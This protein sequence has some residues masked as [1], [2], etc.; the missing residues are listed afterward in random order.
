MYIA[1]EQTLRYR[2]E[3]TCFN[4]ALPLGNGRIGAM[5]YGGV[6]EET[7]SLNEDTL[8]S[9]YPK[10]GNL[11]D[12]PTIHRK[13]MELYE[14][15]SVEEAQK[16]LEGNFGD[17]LVQ[18]YLP[19]ADLKIRTECRDIK[20]YSRYLKLDSA[21]HTVNYQAN[22]KSYT[23]ETLVSEPY[24]VMAVRFQCKEKGSIN[25]EA[26]IEGRLV[27]EKGKL[28]KGNALILYGTAPNCEA[29][30][31][32]FYRN[33]NHQIYDGRGISYFCTFMVKAEG[34]S[35]T[36]YENSVK[37]ENADEAVLYFGVRTNFGGFNQCPCGSEYIEKCLADVRKA[38]GKNYNELKK[39]SIQSHRK[40]YNRMQI[41]LC[42]GIRTRIP[43][44]IRMEQLQ[45][46]SQ[47][48]GLYV[49]LFNYAKYLTITSSRQGT[50][51]MNLQGIWN[52]KLLPPWNSNYTLNINT[53]MNY[54]PTLGLGLFECFEPF[55]VMVEE[56][57]KSGR[58][59]AKNYYGVDG[60][61]CHHSS[62]I[63]RLTH[64]GTNRLPGNAQ[65]GFWNM[66]SGWLSVMLWNYY[67]YT[68]DS[69]YL[70]RVY[71]II[72]GAARF[73]RQLLKEC[74]GEL[75]LPLSTSPENNYVESGEV[76]N[77]SNG[78]VK[79]NIL[80]IDKSTAMTQ[81][82]LWDLFSAVSKAQDI[83]RKENEYEAL[84][85]KLK[86]PIVQSNGELCEWHE[87]H[88]VWDVHHRHVSHLY[89]LFPSNQFI[90]DHKTKEA[91]RKV[92]VSRGDGGTGWSLAWKIN[93]WARLGD[94]EHAL[95]LLQDQLRMVSPVENGHDTGGGSY[96]NLFCAHPPFQID[97]NF[98]AASGIME[99]LIQCDQ[100]GNPILLPALPVEWKKGYV[101]NLCLPG[102]RSISFAWENGRVLWKTIK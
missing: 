92:L 18:M 11:E 50:Q 37:V 6:E 22:S 3:A 76:G 95:Q 28:D 51:A 67:R 59:T 82:I 87:E 35:V 48:N 44:D 43:T 55:I 34:G 49:L 86:R 64:P 39:E 68:L 54:W 23:R 25:F 45:K 9:G 57:E 80:A 13:A 101:K 96:P 61:V 56:L 84:L 85:S 27:C 46:D 30:Y 8:W 19:L 20:R 52:D 26:S 66:S 77:A 17:Y 58:E 32:D 102:K 15:G 2:K 74:D 62:D 29:K 53:E 33:T 90:S 21:V 89:G 40:L 24:Q 63:W 65:W 14:A 81:E 12:Y 1:S 94:G 70:Q 88:E 72:E 99:M 7:I 5:V 71:P 98:G 78:C 4:E 97:G 36:Y 60:W 93:L 75:I 47:D 83:L 38:F 16:L 41:S 69:A 31:G 10:N 73:Y 79:R 100:Y 91:A 42:E